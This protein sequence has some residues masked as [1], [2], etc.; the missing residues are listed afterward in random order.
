M[1][2]FVFADPAAVC[3]HQDDGSLAERG[4]VGLVWVHS[5]EPHCGTGMEL[6]SEMENEARRS[7]YHGGS[8]TPVRLTTLP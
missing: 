2:A 3:G 6:V 8:P 7:T 5:D 4:R 1:H